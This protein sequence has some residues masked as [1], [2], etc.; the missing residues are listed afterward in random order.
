VSTGSSVFTTTTAYYDTGAPVTSTT[1]N[2]TTQYSYD[3]TQTF[4]IQTTLP[5]PSSGVQLATSGSYDQQS[6]AQ[7]SATGMNSGQ[8]VQYAQY[9]RLLR[10]TVVSLPNGGQINY[11]FESTNQTGVVQTTGT[12]QNADT[13][14]LL[15]AYGRTSRVAVYNG[16]SSNPWYETDYCYDATGLLQFQSVPYQGPGFS[17]PIVCSGNG[18]SYIYD[19]LG[20]PTSSTKPDGTASYQ[21]QGRA[22]E[23]TSVNGVQRIT[24]YDPVGRISSVCE[25]SSNS[26]MPGSGSP[27]PCGTDISGTGFLTNYSYN[28]ANHTTTITQGAQTRVFTTDLAGRTTQVS[29]PE[30]G[31]TSYGY[32]YNPTGLQVTRTRPQANQTNP[33]VLTTTTTQYDSLGRPVSISYND[34]LTPTRNFYYDT[35]LP[36]GIAFPTG[37]A[38][39]Q[40]VGAIGP[41]TY[42]LFRYDVMGQL[43]TTYQCMPSVCQDYQLYTRDL[44]EN[45][46]Q[47]SYYTG[48]NT[49]TLISTNYT[50]NPAGQIM[51]ISGGQNNSLNAPSI[52]NVTQEGPFGPVSWTLGNGLWGGRQYDSVG[53]PNAAFTCPN[54]STAPYCGND[55]SALIFYSNTSIIGDEINFN[56]DT[57]VNICLSFNYD[58]FGR[59]T[60]S[61]SYNTPE[62]SYAYDRYGNR[63]QQN[64]LQSGPSPSWSFNANNQITAFAYDAAGNLMN[65]GNHSYQYDAEG[66]VLN[67]DGGTTATYIYSAL[68]RRVEERTNGGATIHDIFYNINGQRAAIW[69][70]GSQTLLQAQTYWSGKPVAYY[71]NGSI[72]YQHQDWQGTERARTSYNGTVEGTFSSLLFG[73]SF[74]VTGADTD[75]YHYAMLDHD[76]ESSTEHAQ[77]RQ[78]NSAQGRWM[79]PDP[80]D[81]S[82]HFG[83]PQSLNRYTYVLNNPI[84][85]VD[86]L[87]LILCDY[88]SSD[89]GGEDF[90]DDEE[91]D[92]DCIAGGGSPVTSQ[93]SVTV[94]PEG[95][96]EV[97]IITNLSLGTLIPVSTSAP[98]NATPKQVRQTCLNNF[99]NTGVGKAVNFFSLASPFIGPDKLQSAIED[100]GGTALKFGAYGFFKTA[101][102]SMAGTPAAA[103]S[104]VVAGTVETVAKSVIAPA[105]T[106][107][108]EVQ[109]GV[110]A[111]CAAYSNPSL[112]PYL[113]PTF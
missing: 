59:V 79:S 24:Q 25:I 70:G 39:G 94:T 89:Q 109:V 21:Y 102:T 50:V 81:G 33:A 97:I 100:V 73:D 8:T 30:R 51:A 58:E 63:W 103:L 48:G 38:K 31:V 34:S 105:A 57:A 19:A 112:Q 110:H 55:F 61:Y 111:A 95:S 84:R 26:S 23:K 82:Y 29:E 54:D 32:L 78:Y 6:G 40:L 86:P 99:N 56:C 46:I 35:P 37:Y 47:D 7:I 1:P 101:I 87:G 91:G 106:L 107:A 75:P 17:A 76:S 62:F 5:T 113:P 53:R 16:Q 74:T 28:L 14:T 64:S 9:D 69:D 80:Y 11:N 88:G 12:G 42:E 98:N 52:V 27:G 18:T 20:R 67:V 71:S 77:F 60:S 65:D 93:Q 72:H 49:G 85:Y 104:S 10:P 68:N 90:E 44:M 3:S 45:V 43:N 15:D 66:N 13:E 4:A 36:N 108:T 2:G 96:S 83:N 22:V 41:S 92:A